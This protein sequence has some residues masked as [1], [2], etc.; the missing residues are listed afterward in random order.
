M[1]ASKCAPYAARS[2]SK[3]AVGTI[4]CQKRSS[5]DFPPFARTT[6]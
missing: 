3:T 4:S 1:K 2:G 6:R 5:A